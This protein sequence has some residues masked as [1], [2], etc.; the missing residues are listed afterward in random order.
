MLFTVQQLLWSIIIGTSLAA[1]YTFYTKRVL[2]S[3]VRQLFENDAFEPESA[4]SLDQI[5]PK[6]LPFIKYSLRDGTSFSETVLC[7]DGKYYIP[8][9]FIDKA[10]RKY[11]GEHLTIIIVM[12]VLIVLLATALICTHLFPEL[13]SLL[14]IQSEI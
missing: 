10:E 14:G 7:S 9:N 4:V 13:L 6:G 3:F 2:G 5:K 11:C 12:V 1:V 8:E